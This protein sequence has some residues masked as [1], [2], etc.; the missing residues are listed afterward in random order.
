MLTTDH[1]TSPNHSQLNQSSYRNYPKQAHTLKLTHSELC[2]I[3]SIHM[4]YSFLCSTHTRTDI[5]SEMAILIHVPWE[6]A[7]S[8]TQELK[9]RETLEIT[10]IC[11]RNDSSS[12]HIYPT[13]NC[14]PHRPIDQKKQLRQQQWHWHWLYSSVGERNLNAEKFDTHLYQNLYY[15]A[16]IRS[17]VYI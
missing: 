11:H 16:T 12:L 7:S 17:T 8:T 3:L 13:I 14:L 1:N 2:L 15:I 5:Y 4:Q 6:V 9:L 10:R